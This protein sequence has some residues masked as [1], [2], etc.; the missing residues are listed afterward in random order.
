[1][2]RIGILMACGALAFAFGC[3]DRDPGIM[4]MDGGPDVDSGPATTPDSGPATT[5]DSGSGDT[6]PPATAPAPS[7]PMACEAATL[8]CLMGATT[9]DA[10]QACLDADADAAGCN[11]CLNAEVISSCSQTGL[12]DDEFGEVQC[13]LMEQC[14]TGEQTCIDGALMGACG[15]DF[16]AFAMCANT[17]IGSMQCGNSATT[18]FMAAGG[19]APSFD[20]P[21]YHQFSRVSREWLLQAIARDGYAR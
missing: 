12:C 13:C 20:R 17:A 5:P 1:M 2:R 19:V 3:D 14:P 8:T 10:Q 21:S 4:L 9:A 16:N 6:C 15:T 7:N 18:C 11:Q